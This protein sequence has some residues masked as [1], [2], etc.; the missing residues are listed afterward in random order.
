M[1]APTKE[2]LFAPLGGVGEIGMNL[3]IYGFGTNRSR[4]W[5]AV[6]FGVAFGGDDLPGVDLI[7]PDIAISSRSG[8]ISPASCSRTRTRIITAR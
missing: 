6:D 2:L 3:A 1:P 7:M 4:T 5:L 8:A